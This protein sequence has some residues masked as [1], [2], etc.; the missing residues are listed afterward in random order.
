MRAQLTAHDGPQELA[1]DLPGEVVY[2]SHPAAA[3]PVAWS[4][5]VTLESQ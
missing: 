4:V 1:A 5:Q 2:R 3:R